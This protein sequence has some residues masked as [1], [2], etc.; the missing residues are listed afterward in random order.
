MTAHDVRQIGQQIGAVSDDIAGANCT[1]RQVVAVVLGWRGRVGLFMRSR[2]VRHDA[3]AWHCI[4]GYLDN[5]EPPM[6][7]AAQEVFEE[8][9]LGVTDLD[10][11]NGGPVLGLPDPRGG[12]PWTVHTFAATTSHRNLRLNWEHDA[13]RWVRP[14]KVPRFDGQV[15]WLADVLKA[16]VGCLPPQ[17]SSAHRLRAASRDG[18]PAVPAFIG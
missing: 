5:G 16:V 1:A 17:Y 3:G 10:Q 8:T 7:R 9:G 2:S 15:P 6:R 4:T 11:L 13:Y 12:R 18:C 14:A